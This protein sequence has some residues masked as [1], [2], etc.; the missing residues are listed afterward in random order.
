MDKVEECY[1]L[2]QHLLARVAQVLQ[3]PPN[4]VLFMAVLGF[5]GLATQQ[6]EGLGEMGTDK[7]KCNLVRASVCQQEYVSSG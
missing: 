1:S 2:T 4:P 6:S 7:D 5:L 3:V